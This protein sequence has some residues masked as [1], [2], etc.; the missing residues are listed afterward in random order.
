MDAWLARHR[1]QLDR[2]ALP[3]AALP[4][5]FELVR[6]QSFT[7]GAHIVLSA[8]AGDDTDTDTGGLAAVAK[9]PLPVGLCFLVDHAWP[10]ASLDDALGTLAQMPALLRRVCDIVGL[11]TD[12]DDVEDGAE[13]ASP[14]AAITRLAP[15]LGSYHAATPPASAGDPPGQLE[16]FYMM[17]EV[18]CRIREAPTE[19]QANCVLASLT[20]AT[21]G[22]GYCVACV[23]RP[24]A[25]E[26]MLLRWTSDPAR[27]EHQR[28]IPGRLLGAARAAGAAEAPAP[29]PSAVSAAAEQGAP[30]G[31]LPVVRFG[32]CESQDT[33]THSSLM[34]KPFLKTQRKLAALGAGRYAAE[35]VHLS[36]ADF[37]SGAAD[38]AEARAAAGENSAQPFCP[39]CAV[40][41]HASSNTSR[42]IGARRGGDCGAV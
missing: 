18:G 40:W 4:A 36:A 37:P 2:S 33:N 22:E 21:T 38:T 19:S 14:L 24:V 11:A 35:Y 41:A 12:D 8:I 10:F 5:V 32:V 29:S 13:A 1:R 42:A 6:A 28:G 39:D 17:D 23:T 15:L 20:D 30:G 16:V 25:E 7:A 34:Y 27:R 9:A 31:P 3:P 26:E